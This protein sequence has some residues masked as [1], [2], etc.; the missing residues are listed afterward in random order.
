MIKTS[1]YDIKR[2][3]IATAERTAEYPTVGYDLC[4]PVNAAGD[5]AFHL[6]YTEM[7]AHLREPYDPVLLPLFLAESME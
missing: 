1:R 5:I 2:A 6:L 3:L 7:R 4:T